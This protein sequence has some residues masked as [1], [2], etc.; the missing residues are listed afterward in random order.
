MFFSK[1]YIKLH[2]SMGSPLKTTIM[3]WIMKWLMANSSQ[4]VVEGQGQNL[5]ELES[6]GERLIEELFNLL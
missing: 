3:M 4:W 1:V 6:E 5:G 2:S